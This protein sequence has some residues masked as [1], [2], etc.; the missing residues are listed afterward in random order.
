LGYT[1]SECAYLA[2]YIDA[3]GTIRLGKRKGSRNGKTYY[4]LCVMVTGTNREPLDWMKAKWGGSVGSHG[5][6]GPR[7]G[8]V[9]ARKPC[10]AWQVSARKAGA[11]LAVVAPFLIVKKR[12]CATGLQF[13]AYAK[14]HRTY[15][16]KPLPPDYLETVETFQR[17][18]RLWNTRGIVERQ[19]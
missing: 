18:M 5:K 12:Q 19:G 9:I 13:F 15:T 14:A 10:Y 2:G 3:D 6:V 8:A 16:G 4:V 11:V 17:Q 7:T 1:E